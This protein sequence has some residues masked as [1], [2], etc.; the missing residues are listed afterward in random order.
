MRYIHI[1]WKINNFYNYAVHSKG[2]KYS[3]GGSTFPVY[4]T[5]IYICT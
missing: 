2:C 3:L 1:S 5:K 4:I